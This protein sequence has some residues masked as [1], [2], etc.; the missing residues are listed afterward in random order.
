M[1]AMVL[2]VVRSASRRERGVHSGDNPSLRQHGPTVVFIVAANELDR[3]EVVARMRTM[4]LILPLLLMISLLIA[5][6]ESHGPASV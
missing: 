5:V 6:A 1:P 2:W 4:V 3:F